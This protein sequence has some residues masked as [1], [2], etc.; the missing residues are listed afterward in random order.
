MKKKRKQKHEYFNVRPLDH[1][2]RNVSRGYHTVEEENIYLDACALMTRFHDLPEPV[3]EGRGEAELEAHYMA[4]GGEVEYQ[5]G[6]RAM[7]A[8]EAMERGITHFA[9]L[10]VAVEDAIGKEE[11]YW[12]HEWEELEGEEGDDKTVTAGLTSYLKLHERFGSDWPVKALLLYIHEYRTGRWSE[13]ATRV[14]WNE[15]L[16][17]HRKL[18][19]AA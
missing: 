11:M 8:F 14:H 5:G 13:E 7:A 16:A 19:L 18:K 6:K 3:I 10:W 15:K 17:E 9:K 4:F 12:E 2:I 1:L